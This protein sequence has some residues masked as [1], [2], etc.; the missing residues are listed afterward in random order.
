VPNRWGRNLIHAR[1][2][3]GSMGSQSLHDVEVSPELAARVEQLLRLKG[4][5]GTLAELADLVREKWM[6]DHF[7]SPLSYL[8]AVASGRS[9]FG[10]V[11]YTTRHTVRLSGGESVHTGCAFDAIVEGFFRPIQIE[12]SCPHCG[13]AI[14]LRMS[15]GEVSSVSPKS[16]VLWLA[17]ST[18]N[19]ECQGRCESE[20]E[21]CPHTNLFA[22]RKHLTSWTAK[23]PKELG[24]ALTLQQ[25][26]LLVREGWWKPIRSAASSRASRDRY[27]VLIPL[28]AS[29][30]SCAICPAGG[31][32]NARPGGSSLP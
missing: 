3:P 16:A 23:H 31:V 22:S 30:P 15:H 21:M 7:L 4:T 12:S 29:E 32:P 28:S 6:G 26:L 9:V 27:S 19:G 14:R 5:P 25:T 13:E 2:N 8:K 20:I 10:G 1:G 17:A 24:M 18:E 11:S